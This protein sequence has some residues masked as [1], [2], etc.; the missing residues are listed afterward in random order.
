L[1]TGRNLEIDSASKTRDFYFAAKR[2]EHDTDGDFTIQIGVIAFEYGV[3]FDVDLNKKIS[4]GCGGLT[5]F[6]FT[7]KANAISIVNAT[8]YFDG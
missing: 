5:C 2:C 4:V 8:R 7:G 1:G 6:S 3:R